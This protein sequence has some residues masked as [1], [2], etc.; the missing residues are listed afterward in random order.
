MP[1]RSLSSSVL[2][3]PDADQV[4][5]AVVAWTAHTCRQSPDVRAVGYFGSYARGDWGVGSDL[6]LLV[7]VDG[8]A[9]WHG[10]TEDLPVPAEVT[11]F[12]ERGWHD[13]LARGDR[14]AKTLV[15][16]TVWVTEPPPRGD[17]PG[18]ASLHSVSSSS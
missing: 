8:D 11:V 3:W 5:A 1:T 2:R 15:A 4:H 14:F 10:R 6:D 9:S 12:T 16:E 17:E 13:R 18:S 7:L